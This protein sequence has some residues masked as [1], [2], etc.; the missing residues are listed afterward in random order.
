MQQNSAILSRGHN[1]GVKHFYAS[2]EGGLLP[3]V[4]AA[5]ALGEQ[6]VQELCSLGAIYLNEKRVISLAEANVK[7][8]DYLRVHAEPR[9]Y[10]LHDTDL[11]GLIYYENADFVVVNKPSGLPAHATVDNLTENM[12]SL[13]TQKMGIDL[14][15]THRL[16]IATQ[17]LMVLAKTSEF[18]SAFNEELRNSRIKKYYRATVQGVPKVGRLV[19]YMLPSPRAPK[20]VSR[21]LQPGWQ[22]CALNIL[23]VKSVFK[24]F[25][26]IEIELETGRTHQIRAQLSHEGYPI[27]GDV[28]YGGVSLL[29]ADRDDMVEELVSSSDK[30]ALQAFRLKFFNYDFQLNQSL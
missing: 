22:M 13:L 15:I 21:D 10:V 3:V 7:K 5:L 23:C 19:H 28:A 17:G 25:S 8:G 26:E 9:R 4:N 18:Q 24:D 20:K 14:K 27:L 6:R 30:I 29:E 1:Y 16:D 11:A 2:Q 12:L